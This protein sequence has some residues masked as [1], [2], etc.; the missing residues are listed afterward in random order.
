MS[1][2]LP[3]I[4][5]QYNGVSEI[6]RHGENGFVI[7]NPLDDKAIFNCIQTLSD[8]AIRLN[9]GEKGAETASAF[10][11][12]RNISETLDVIQK[13]LNRND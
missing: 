5:T 1:H 2:G 6:I 11:M 10:T 4:T 7:Q 13:V 9:I 3:V 12:Q 8:K